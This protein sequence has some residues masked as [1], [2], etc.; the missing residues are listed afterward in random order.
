MRISFFDHANQATVDRLLAEGAEDLEG[1][2]E[3][4]S[5]QATLANVEEMIEGYEYATDDVI[6][7]KTSRGA[8][9]LIQA[10]LLEEL[11]ALDKVRAI[12]VDLGLSL[13]RRRRI[14]IP[15]W[16]PTIV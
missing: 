8:A 3:D 10:R 2:G 14:Y 16:N 5:A 6:G 12:L 7:R 11:A 1:E 4:E 9:D 15:S 13:T